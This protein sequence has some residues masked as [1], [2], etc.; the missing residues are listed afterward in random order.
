[1]K[2]HAPFPVGLARPEGAP[3]TRTC[4]RRRDT[5]R[6][7]C[8]REVG[9][10]LAKREAVDAVSEL[11]V[12]PHERIYAGRS[13][14]QTARL[15]DLSKVVGEQIFHIPARRSRPR[16]KQPAFQSLDDLGEG[17]LRSRCAAAS[18]LQPG[19]AAGF[20]ELADAQDVALAL[21][22]RDHAAGVEQIEIVGGAEHLLIGR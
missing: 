10:E 4:L 21:G 7:C 12:I 5:Q 8:Q 1:M 19:G 2:E 9:C 11:G 22:D 14:I 3:K 16:I 20:G 15:A 6:I 13:V 17:H 18:R